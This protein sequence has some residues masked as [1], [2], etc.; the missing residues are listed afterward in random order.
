MDVPVLVS[1]QFAD[2]LD[3]EAMKISV[4]IR[5]YPY[6]SLASRARAEG[7]IDTGDNLLHPRFYVRHGLEEWL[8]ATVFQW[9]AG[10]PNWKM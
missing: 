6:T 4:G 10:R 8:R 1:L 9:I 5:I 2:S 7:I 3:L